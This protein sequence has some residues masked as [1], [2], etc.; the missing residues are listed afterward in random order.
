MSYFVKKVAPEWQGVFK[1]GD[2]LPELPVQVTADLVEL[3]YIQKTAPKPK[4]NDTGKKSR[5]SI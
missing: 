5:D 1:V 2:E 4:K 3:G